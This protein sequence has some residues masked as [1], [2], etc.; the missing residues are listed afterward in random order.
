MT[1]KKQTP[2][3]IPM[4][5]PDKPKAYGWTK[6]QKKLYKELIAE[7]Q[8][9]SQAAAV[10]VLGAYNKVLGNTIDVFAEELGIA[11]DG[12]DYEVDA[13]KFR[14]IVRPEEPKE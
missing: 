8:E 11:D 7:A 6:T 13:Q 5:K 3:T 10:L 12:N 14:F 1:K 9:K 2:K 4:T